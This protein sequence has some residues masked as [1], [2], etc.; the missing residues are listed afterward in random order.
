MSWKRPGGLEVRD[1]QN[2]P[3]IPGSKLTLF[4][5]C[6]NNVQEN[7]TLHKEP[8]KGKWTKTTKVKAVVLPITNPKSLPDSIS[9]VQTHPKYR[10]C[11]TIKSSAKALS[12][13]SNTSLLWTIHKVKLC[14]LY[15]SRSN[16]VSQFGSSCYKDLP[17]VIHIKGHISLWK[18]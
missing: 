13:I 8:G 6:E 17:T 11:P 15:C 3:W 5:A 7:R 18:E 16:S 2:W 14:S 4:P 10:W 9:K 1:L 12:G